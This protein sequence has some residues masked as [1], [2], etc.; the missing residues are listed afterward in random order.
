MNCENTECDVIWSLPLPCHKLLHFLRPPSE[1]GI[2]YRRI[3]SYYS[4]F[5]IQHCIWKCLL[6][7][8]S[9]AAAAELHTKTDI[10]EM[11]KNCSL[12]DDPRVGSKSHFFCVDCLEESDNHG[13]CPLCRPI[14][15][16]PKTESYDRYRRQYFK[17]NFVDLHQLFVERSLNITG[18]K[19]FGM[20]FGILKSYIYVYR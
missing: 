20:S 13:S 15:S 3:L 16:I 8:F 19:R 11:I 12:Y 4:E 6:L 17:G 2:L 14:H 5:V 10:V 1:R 18:V 7:I 9:M